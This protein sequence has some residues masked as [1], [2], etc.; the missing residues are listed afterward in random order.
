MTSKIPGKINPSNPQPEHVNRQSL[1]LQVG[2]VG[3]KL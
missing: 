2:I 3:N 1:E